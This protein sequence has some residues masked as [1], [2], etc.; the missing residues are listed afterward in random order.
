M[1][2]HSYNTRSKSDVVAASS[3]ALAEK[4]TKQYRRS[5]LSLQR[6]LRDRAVLLELEMEVMYT[7]LTLVN[8]RLERMHET[9]RD[10]VDMVLVPAFVL[11]VCVVVLPTA[12]PTLCSLAES[13]RLA[14]P[15]WSSTANKPAWC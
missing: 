2:T 8:T 9:M 7:Q 5:S 10:V 14:M 11:F 3:A 1:P 6:Q 12:W 13:V 4:D 15:S